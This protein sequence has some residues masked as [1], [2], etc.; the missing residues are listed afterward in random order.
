[1]FN[2]RRWMSLMLI[3]VY[4]TQICKYSIDEMWCCYMGFTN[5][6][7]PISSDGRRWKRFRRIF[8]RHFALSSGNEGTGNTQ[9][10]L[11]RCNETSDALMWRAMSERIRVGL[12][13]DVGPDESDTQIFTAGLIDDNIYVAIYFTSYYISNKFNI[14]QFFVI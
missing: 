8:T 10:R 7:W 3:K 13:A 2:S 4:P 5:V 12:Y 1:M 14:A 6:C 9:R 11:T